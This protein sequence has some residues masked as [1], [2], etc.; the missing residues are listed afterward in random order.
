[1]DKFT[2]HKQTLVGSRFNLECAEGNVIELH[3][4]LQ[5]IILSTFLFLSSVSDV[6]LLGTHKPMPCSKEIYMYHLYKQ[7]HK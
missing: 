2:M 5:S 1:M 4:K 7:A 3:N 6:L